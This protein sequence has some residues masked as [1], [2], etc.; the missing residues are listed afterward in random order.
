MILLSKGFIQHASLAPGPPRHLVRRTGN[1]RTSISYPTMVRHQ[2][3]PLQDQFRDCTGPYTPQVQ[4]QYGRGDGTP[5][6]SHPNIKHA[7]SKCFHSPFSSLCIHN[8]S[9]G[10]DDFNTPSIDM[11]Y[12]EPHIY[13]YPDAHPVPAL[14]SL[15][16]SSCSP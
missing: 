1:N 5:Y 15:P 3:E 16:C 14:K 4:A 10:D 9:V 7:E 8:F 6:F 11:G 2:Q 13:S 12:H